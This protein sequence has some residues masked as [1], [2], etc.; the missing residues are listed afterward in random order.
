VRVIES[1]DRAGLA[2]EARAALFV[3]GKL[4]GQDL[5]GDRPVEPRV[6]GAVDLVHPPGAEGR[7]ELVRTEARS[8][9]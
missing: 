8:D 3:P 5:D 4:R 7:E 2:L 1:G 9:R 6:A